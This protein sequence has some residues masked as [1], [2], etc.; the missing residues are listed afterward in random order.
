MYL[1]DEIE[2]SSDGGVDDWQAGVRLINRTVGKKFGFVM[3]L[4][5]NPDAEYPDDITTAICKW[6]EKEVA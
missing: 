3:S 2:I 6:V 1:G 5:K 4:E